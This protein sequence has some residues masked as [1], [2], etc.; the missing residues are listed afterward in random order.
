[1]MLKCTYVY[2]RGQLLVMSAKALLASSMY[3]AKVGRNWTIG[4]PLAVSNDCLEAGIALTSAAVQADHGCFCARCRQQRQPKLC[5]A[6]NQC[7]ICQV[8]SQAACRDPVPHCGRDQSLPAPLD[9]HCE[10][11]DCL[12]SHLHV[13]C[14]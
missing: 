1:M 5:E 3:Y 7:S 13:S 12:F 14:C 10:L 4:S 8:R 6:G 2:E 9:S 11:V